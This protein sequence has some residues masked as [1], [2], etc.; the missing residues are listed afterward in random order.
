MEKYIRRYLPYVAGRKA[1]GKKLF[2]FHKVFWLADLL[3]FL[4]L[5]LSLCI[6]GKFLH[7]LTKMF[8]SLG[9][10]V[11]NIST[12]PFRDILVLIGL[13]TDS[14]G[15]LHKYHISILL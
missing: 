9:K 12:P 13:V 5:S 11:E 3:G 15:T 2:Q 1:S 4:H 10:G 6:S 7:L 14:T 8:Q